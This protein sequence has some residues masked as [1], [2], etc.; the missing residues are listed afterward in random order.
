VLGARVVNAPWRFPT[1]PTVTDE[2]RFSHF[3]LRIQERLLLQNDTPVLL[4]ARAFDVLCVL[5][6]NAGQLVT[7]A[8]LFDKVW[9]GLVVEENNLQVH[10]STLRKVLGPSAIATVPGH[11]YRLTAPLQPSSPAPQQLLAQFESAS[12]R[13]IAVLPFTDEDP[14]DAAAYLAEGLAEGV[15][16]KLSRSRWFFV[17]AHPSSRA[18]RNGA[19]PLAEVSR[20]LGARYLVVGSLRRSAGTLR[21]QAQLV[22]GARNEVLWSRRYDRPQDDVF[23]VQDDISASIASAIEPVYLRREEFLHSRTARPDHHHWELLMRAR[24][25]F[26]RTTR[27]HVDQAQT[28]LEQALALQ[29]DDPACLSLMAFVHMTR[30][31]SGWTTTARADIQNATR[32]AMRAVRED[33][34]NSFSHFTLGTALSLSHNLQ[35]AIHEL[36]LALTLYPECAAAAGELGRLLAFSGRTQEAS[37]FILQAIDASPHDPHLSLWLRSRA[38]ACFVEGDAAQAVQHARQALAKRPDWFFNYH[39][40]AAC[41]AADGQTDEARRTLERGEQ[42]GRYSL[43]AIRVGHPFGDEAVMNRFLDALRL[44]GWTPSDSPVPSTPRETS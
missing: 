18:F 42:L 2:L 25:H 14:Q 28:L 31:W 35:Q 27:Y 5:A 12:T 22:D 10:V 37:G 15:I 8:M 16:E 17:I 29:P 1:D 7:K 34:T 11:G 4:G 3:V 41:L 36:E 6:L 44:A 40:L 30:V 24:W 32:L 23:A 21:V 33:D 26:W 20:A 13:S 43:A 9:P 38:I 39:L 19:K